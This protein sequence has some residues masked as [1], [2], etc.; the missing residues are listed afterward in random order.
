MFYKPV[1]VVGVPE[2]TTE[3]Q[4]RLLRFE[5]LLKKDYTDTIIQVFPY[6]EAVTDIGTKIRIVDSPN[7]VE[8]KFIKGILTNPPEVSLENV[9]YDIDFVA[10]TPN[11]DELT[12]GKKYI[13]D[14]I[15]IPKHKVA[16]K[17]G[18]QL[19]I[20]GFKEH[21]KNTV[22]VTRKDIE[23]FKEHAGDLDWFINSFAP[24]IIPVNKETYLM[25]LAMAVALVRGSL[26][27]ERNEIH[28]LI[29]GDPSVGKTDIA[30]YILEVDPGSTYVSGR[31]ASGVG[32][33]VAVV[34]ENGRWVT[35]IG[36]IPY[37]N[38]HVAIIDEFD[39][40]SDEDRGMLYEVLKNGRITVSKAGVKQVI[41]A[42][43]SVIGLAN[44]LY[45]SVRDKDIHRLLQELDLKPA[46]VSRFDVVLIVP[47]TVDEE[48][49][50]KI[51][52]AMI[53][54]F[55]GNTVDRV[56]NTETMKKFIAYVRNLKVEIPD[57]IIDYI[58]EKFLTLRKITQNERYRFTRRNLAGI[59]RVATAIAKLRQSTVLTKEDIDLAFE[60]IENTLS[61]Q[62]GQ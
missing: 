24:N 17:R 42:K 44:P 20:V 7:N 51:A 30:K 48:V 46:L 54:R 39:K 55:R 47:D 62:I 61:I 29:I 38:G 50:R 40:I 59:L 45:G 49:D 4:P 2:V 23:K 41:P 27:N 36:K 1:R 53:E 6:E 16:Y 33:T 32:L 9:T 58:M 35:K 21:D 5:A 15:P 28:T 26:E 52:R 34:R 57:E 10:E 11:L 14:A 56:K 8:V 13:F 25:K 60:M 12:P 43:T 18:M 22:R 31:R 37:A 3:K 19:Y